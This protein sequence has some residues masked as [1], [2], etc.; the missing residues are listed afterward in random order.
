MPKKIT[1]ISKWLNSLSVILPTSNLIEYY[2]EAKPRKKWIR[3]G[4]PFNDEESADVFGI[5]YSNAHP[6]VM[7][8]VVLEQS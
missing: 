3:V 7:V 1:T 5:A 8:R 6:N 2:V 4:G